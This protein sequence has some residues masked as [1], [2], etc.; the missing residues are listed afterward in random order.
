VGCQA[1]PLG[2]FP[3]ARREGGSPILRQG[4]SRQ[5]RAY[6]VRIQR[7][8]RTGRAGS[9]SDEAGRAATATCKA[10]AKLSATEFEEGKSDHP[11]S[12]ATSTALKHAMDEHLLSHELPRLRHP[13]N[14]IYDRTSRGHKGALLGDHKREARFDGGEAKSDSDLGGGGIRW[15]DLIR[16]RPIATSGSRSEWSKTWGVGGSTEAGGGELDCARGR[17]RGHQ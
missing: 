14:S 2:T 15:D 9:T 3:R 17:W 11:P 5:R 8:P 13:G 4:E 10:G 7:R 12:K 6:G 1:P 16:R